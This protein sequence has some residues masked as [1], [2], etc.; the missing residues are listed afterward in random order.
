MHFS[1]DSEKPLFPHLPFAPCWDRQS[2]CTF[3]S[4]VWCLHAPA[5]H[6]V[7]GM[8]ITDC[9][10]KTKTK[11]ESNLFE[12]VS[13]DSLRVLYFIISNYNELSM[14][15]RRRYM[16]DRR[17]SQPS[18]SAKV[19]LLCCLC[20]RKSLK[21]LVQQVQLTVPDL[22]SFHTKKNSSQKRNR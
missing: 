8:L 14:L 22:R 11:P 17:Q 13:C 5:Q 19:G 15:P 4:R 6:T 12:Q 20:F 7:R 21:Q 9:Q 2:R 1:F 10:Q 3:A 16:S 18:F